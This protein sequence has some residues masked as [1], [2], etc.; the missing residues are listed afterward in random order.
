MPVFFN[1]MVIQNA[2]GADQNEMEH[3]LL[4]TENQVRD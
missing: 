2:N 3:V 4:T 1:K